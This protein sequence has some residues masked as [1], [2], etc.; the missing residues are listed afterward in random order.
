[1]YMQDAIILMIACWDIFIE[2]CIQRIIVICMLAQKGRR[3]V[4]NCVMAIC[5]LDIYWGPMMLSKN[6]MH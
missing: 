2:A 1:M 5:M 4:D 3:H 6:S